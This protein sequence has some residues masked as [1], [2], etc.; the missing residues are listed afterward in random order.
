MSFEVGKYARHKKTGKQV[1][2]VYEDRQTITTVFL[3]L[4]ENTHP[5]LWVNESGLSDWNNPPKLVMWAPALMKSENS[6]FI[7][8]QYFSSSADA[9]KAEKSYY[10]KV[11]NWPAYEANWPMLP[12]KVEK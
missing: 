10:G 8:N 1:L 4:D 3:C 5:T 6:Y 9:D 7:T 2:I 11:Y 12:E